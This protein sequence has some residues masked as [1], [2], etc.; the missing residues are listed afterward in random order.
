MLLLA[1]IPSFFSAAAVAHATLTHL[2]LVTLTLTLIPT[3][4]PPATT[5]FIPRLTASAQPPRSLRVSPPDCLVLSL[6]VFF[7]FF[8]RGSFHLN[9]WV[10]FSDFLRLDS[11]VE[12]WI[13]AR[14][15]VLWLRCGWCLWVLMMIARYYNCF[16]YGITVILRF[17]YGFFS[18]YNKNTTQG[19]VFFFFFWVW[20]FLWGLGM[21]YWFPNFDC[22]SSQNELNLYTSF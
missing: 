20:V 2:P 4:L 13:S 17:F 9:H 7:F 12:E 1:L 14:V 22:K 8:F 3:S 18:G 19:R 11:V 10:V 5:P 6:F 15:A 16:D 21:G